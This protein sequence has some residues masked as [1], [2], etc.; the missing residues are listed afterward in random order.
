MSDTPHFVKSLDELYPINQQ[1]IDEDAYLLHE[2]EI[3]TIKMREAASCVTL[4]DV[5]YMI[6]K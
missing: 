6:H 4:G 3:D 1:L 5:G 2:L